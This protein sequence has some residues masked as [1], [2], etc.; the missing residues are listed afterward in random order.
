M[1]PLAK[2]FNPLYNL[3]DSLKSR[4]H[5]WNKRAMMLFNFWSKQSTEEPIFQSKS[6]PSWM[7]QQE[8]W[9][10]VHGGNQNA[11]LDS[12]LAQAPTLATLK[13]SK[14]FRHLFPNQRRTTT[15][16]S[17]RSGA[18]S[19]TT[20]SWS[21]SGIKNKKNLAF[22]NFL[23]CFHCRTKWDKDVDRMSLNPSK[24]TFE[25]MISGM[26]MGELVRLVVEDMI[27]EGLIFNNMDTKRI[28]E[29]GAFPTRCVHQT[30]F[31]W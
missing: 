31:L 17:T 2:P 10:H 6:S 19:G 28:Q 29:R 15:W 16:S 9:C 23:F 26:Y 24:Q 4:F 25:K 21:S 30:S 8:L 13:M 11:E 5:L 18:P 3:M 27:Q 1:K 22:S 14:R 7:T 20:G 12:S